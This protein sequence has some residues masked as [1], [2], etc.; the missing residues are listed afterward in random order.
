MQCHIL[1]SAVVAVI[2]QLRNKHAGIPD[3][4]RSINVQECQALLCLY[5]A[6]AA[7]D[8]LGLQC[9]VVVRQSY[10]MEAAAYVGCV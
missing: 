2:E 8:Q 3:A 7:A 9:C 10:K 5:L 6:T 4:G 1:T